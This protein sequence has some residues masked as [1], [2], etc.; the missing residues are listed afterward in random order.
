MIRAFNRTVIP[1]ALGDQLPAEARREVTFHSLRGA[2]K[3]ML[4]TGNGV[5]LS[6]VNEVVGHAS[7]DLDQRYIGEITIEETYPAIAGCNYNG[8]SLPQTPIGTTISKAHEPVM[9]LV[10]Q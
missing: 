6:M 5:P 2:F 7:S 3:A 10:K 9:L 1:D 8:L 4:V